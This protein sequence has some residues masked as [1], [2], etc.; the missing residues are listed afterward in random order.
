M[1]VFIRTAILP[2]LFLLTVHAA[3]A[4]C[5]PR[6]SAPGDGASS[7]EGVTVT[8]E[9]PSSK[10]TVGEIQER[11]SKEPLPTQKDRAI[12]SHRIPRDNNS[13]P[14]AEPASDNGFK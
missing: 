12:H 1:S 4:A 14:A 6:R 2:F 3:H 11:E 13:V 5:G 10:E 9:V 8:K 7:R